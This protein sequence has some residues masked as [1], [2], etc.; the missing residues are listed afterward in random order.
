MRIILE[1]A[2]VG[3]ERARLLGNYL[4]FKTQTEGGG[5]PSRFGAKSYRF[6]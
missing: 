5:E 1:N 6:K 2:K 4:N 3:L